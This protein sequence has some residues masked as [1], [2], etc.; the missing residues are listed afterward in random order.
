[1]GALAIAG[2]FPLAG[3]FSKDAILFAAMTSPRGGVLFWIA[4]AAGALMTAFYMFRLV[5]KTFHGPCTLSLEQQHH[6]HESPRTMTLPLQVLAVLAIVGGWVGLPLVPGADALGGFLAPAFGGPAEGHHEV[7]FEIVMMLISLAIAFL[8]ISMAYSLYV[9]RP[10]GGAAYA[11][12]W[13][14]LYRLLVNKYY[15]DEAYDALIVQPV[16]RA[17]IWAWRAFDDGFVDAAVNG[18]GGFVQAAGGALRRLQTGY[19]KSY[20]LTML[21]GALAILLYLSV[22]GG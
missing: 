4:G 14:G 5:F 22:R 13:P 6:L 8:G 15:V 17:S 3:F 16:K 20:A 7:V 9:L 1:V 2:V 10:G 18:T 12:R 11:R 21:A 19:V